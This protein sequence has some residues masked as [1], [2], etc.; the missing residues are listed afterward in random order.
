MTWLLEMFFDFFE[1]VYQIVERM[2]EN[3]KKEDDKNDK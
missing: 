1:N 3:M 2:R